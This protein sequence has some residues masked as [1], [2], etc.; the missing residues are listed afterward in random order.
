VQG[1]V[2]GFIDLVFRCRERYYIID[3]KS[4]YLGAS[5]GD[6]TQDALRKAMHEHYYILQYHIYTVALHHYLAL[7]DAAYDYDKNFGGSYYCFVRGISRANGPI[8]GIYR[9][10]PSKDM[11]TALSNYLTG[12]QGAKP[13]G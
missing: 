2:R 10:R 9:D 8:C 5:P 11:V 1:Y 13:H 6:Y 12:G 7:R 3:W 4:N